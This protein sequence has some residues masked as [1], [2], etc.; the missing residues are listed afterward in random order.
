MNRVLFF[1]VL[2]SSPSLALLQLTKADLFACP[3]KSDFYKYNYHRFMPPGPDAGGA[4][5]Q[6]SYKECAQKQ[7]L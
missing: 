5:E 7:L 6:K 3:P 2:S 1:Q 4:R